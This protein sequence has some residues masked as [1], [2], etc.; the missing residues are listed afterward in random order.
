[1]ARIREH[2]WLFTFLCLVLSGS[3]TMLAIG[4]VRLEDE[5]K[6]SYATS[7]IQRS[8]HISA[9]SDS[10][11]PLCETVWE[12]TGDFW[13]DYTYTPE[14]GANR[15][16]SQLVPNAPY[17]TDLGV[18]SQIDCS[19]ASAND[20][21]TGRVAAYPVRQTTPKTRALFGIGLVFSVVD[22]LVMIWL[23]ALAS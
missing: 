15:T 12:C 18:N 20:F 10:F 4:S 8:C 13:V 11:D 3:V 9:V 23:F 16:Q 5:L 1:M 2:P 14:T 19:A 7:G 21:A 6:L 17:F 22:I